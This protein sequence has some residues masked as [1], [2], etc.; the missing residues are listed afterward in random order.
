MEIMD[1]YTSQKQLTK[2]TH[3]RDVPMAKDEYRFVVSVLVFNSLGEL[4]IQKRHPTKHSWANYWDFTASGAVDTGEELYQAAQRELFE[5]MGI[6]VDF[7]NVPSRLTV[8]FEEGWDEIYFVE[9]DVN[10][11]DLKLQTTEVSEAKWVTEA[12]LLALIDQG[13]FI[14][15]IYAKSV[16]DYYRSPSEHLA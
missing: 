15:Y 14:P 8:R 6:A 16:F 4:L 12:E 10:L 5:E 1:V 9:K 3:V 2:K 11:A 7:Q 13:V